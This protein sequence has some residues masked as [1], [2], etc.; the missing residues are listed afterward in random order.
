MR[1]RITVIPGSE[2]EAANLRVHDITR[3]VELAAS[4]LQGHRGMLVGSRDGQQFLLS[5]SDVYYFETVDD[6]TFAYTKAQTY[7]LGMRLYELE[8]M[9]D[10]RFFR[11]SKSQIVNVLMIESVRSEMNGR[12]LATLL[13]GDKLI[14]S[15]GY[16]KELKRRLGL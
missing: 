3:E 16:V 7:E 9:L 4:L 1:V 10:K 11:S 13:S 12:M 8:A 15:R 5:P 14:V 2:E 6:R